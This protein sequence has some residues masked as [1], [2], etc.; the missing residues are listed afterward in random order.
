MKNYISKFLIPILFM[1]IGHLAIAD[2]QKNKS[3]AIQNKL[4]QLENGFDGKI[5]VY[6]VNTENNQVVA[7]RADE[8]FPVQ[9]TFKVI[10]VAALLNK[11]KKDKNL[12][13]QKI[14]YSSQELVGWVPIT[15]LHVNEGMTLA[16]LSAATIS[17]SDNTAVNLIIKQIGGPQAVTDFAHSIG[18]KTFNVVHYEANLNS[19]PKDTRDTST[20]KD[21]AISL[22]KIV[23]GNVLTPTDKQL[24]LSWLKNNTTG[25]QRIRAGVP[26]GWIVADKTGSGSYGIAND[27]AV[28]WS[29]A[30]KPIVL[31]IYTNQKS[32]EAKSRDDIVALVTKA[33]FDDFAKKNNCIYS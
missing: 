28:V 12:L 10:A 4:M 14:I 31:A 33:V 15:K 19:D 7:Y 17:Y 21:M 29:P 27:I 9:S 30:C 22:E 1:A 3:I 11:S 25:N 26:M 32:K 18:N 20:P 13:Q 5:G 2:T 8:L 16:A 23:L 24:L 6:A